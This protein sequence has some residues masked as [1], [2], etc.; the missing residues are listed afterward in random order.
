MGKVNV[1]C[2]RLGIKEGEEFPLDEKVFANA[3]NHFKPA[4]SGLTSS[5]GLAIADPE[6]RQMHWPVLGG[7]LLRVQIET[8]KPS[9]KLVKA[10]ARKKLMRKYPECNWPKEELIE[11]E[12]VS[13]AEIWE[14]MDGEHK[15]VWAFVSAKDKVALVFARGPVVEKVTHLLRRVFGTFP[16]KN[17]WEGHL[18]SEAVRHYIIGGE[19]AADFGIEFTND[20]LLKDG[21]KSV[22]LVDADDLRADEVVNFTEQAMTPAAA[23]LLVD[24]KAW[25]LATPHGRLT[26][27]PVATTEQD[28]ED[29]ESMWQM[30]CAT[31]MMQTSHTLEMAERLRAL[32][33]HYDRDAIVELPLP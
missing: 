33:A 28:L 32:C 17:L 15:F 19:A 12:E 16:V 30:E 9:P 31:Q 11:A 21:G 7:V 13:H 25:A 1:Q 18:F 6:E 24:G 5:I 4:I 23:G 3:L 8:R 2:L 26:M 20:L 27:E 10:S 14:K 22:R 29:A